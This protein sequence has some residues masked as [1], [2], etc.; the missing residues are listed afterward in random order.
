[1]LINCSLSSSRFR[2]CHVI[3]TLFLAGLMPVTAVV[4]GPVP[5]LDDND[6]VGD[7]L[8]TQIFLC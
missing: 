2:E 8:V 7:E 3:H 6:H 4:K 1:M 5:V